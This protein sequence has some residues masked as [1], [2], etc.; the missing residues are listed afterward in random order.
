MEFNATQFSDDLLDPAPTQ[1]PDSLPADEGN[2]Q[3]TEDPVN[4]ADPTS[5]PAPAD[6]SEL[7]AYQRFLK[8]RGVKDGK[9][10]T[11]EDEETGEVNEV[12]F[13]TLSVEEQFNILDELSKPDLSEDEA[14]TIDY[15]R[16]NGV[17][18]QEVIEY[19]QNLAVQKYIEEN[20]NPQPT[21][22]SVDKYSDEELFLADIKSQY[23]DMTNEELISE[24]DN[25]QSNTE[26]FAKKVEA[27]RKKYKGFEEQA[28]KEKEAEREAQQKEVEATFQ[29]TLDE[30][31]Y[32]PMDYKKPD[33]GSIQ[34]D[35]DEK[36]AVY[37]YLFQQ[38]ANGHTGFMKDL[39]DPQKVVRMAYLMQFSDQLLSDM[40]NYWKGELKKTRASVAT[41]PKATTTVVKPTSTKKQTFNDSET[42]SLSPAWEQYI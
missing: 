17:S 6:D 25:A 39:N 29:K 16:R 5:E 1:E 30:F 11:F 12:D 38:D 34:V 23:P 36:A 15:L 8:S 4:Q 24:L 32:I 33:A 28:L 26:L 7:D 21:N 37:S 20:Q 14:Q 19:Y 10:I 42:T 3:T 9:M 35:P 22:Y 18:M 41:P 13:S 27:I 2:V 31:N 40:T